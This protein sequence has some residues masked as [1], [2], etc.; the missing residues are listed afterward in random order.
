[1]QPKISII[2]PVYNVEKY[3]EDCLNSI[4]NQNFSDY[5]II[6]VNDG[7]TDDSSQ[8][9][10]MYE[11]KIQK[12]KIIHQENKGLSEARNT[13]IRFA[14]GVYICFVDSDDMLVENSLKIMWEAVEN[15]YPDIVG[16]ETAEL[17]Y[18]D[19]KLR[20]IENKDEYYRVVGEYSGIKPGREFFVEMI[21]NNDFVESAWLMLIRR[22]WL[23]NKNCLFSSGVLY[24]DS[25][26]AIECYFKCEKM[27]HIKKQL[28][29]YR[30]RHNSI[31][32]EKYRFKH[33]YFRIWQFSECLKVIYTYARNQREI[34]ALSKYAEQSMVNIKRIN[35]YLT[36]EEK[37]KICDLDS[38]YGL[39]AKSMGITS[40]SLD[41]NKELPLLGLLSVIEK[42]PQLILYGAGLVGNK[43][44]HYLEH[45][46]LKDKI[47]GF[48]VS[49]N[50]IKDCIEEIPVRCIKDYKPSLNTL[51]IIS[52]GENYHKEMVD[53]AKVIGFK[54]ILIIDYA[55]ECMIDEKIS[56]L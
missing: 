26:F 40:I 19:E 17:L 1:M 12:I 33:I 21:E 2:V 16:Y 46:G 34:K 35:N 6:C 27:K 36:Y 18:E 48:A 38:L 5:E 20:E 29:V 7:S 39:I 14:T 42:Y 11:N 55:L 45:I 23:K 41:Y 30:V 54:N 15:E 53:E 8:I 37:E 13:G 43:L 50:I 51:L 22:D 3:L 52:A 4:L 24:E 25:I 28:Y 10:K 49:G 56:I 9:L 44:M 47:L 31:M 32:T